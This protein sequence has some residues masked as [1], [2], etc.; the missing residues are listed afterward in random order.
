[1]RTVG[2]RVSGAPYTPPTQQS[3]SPKRGAL[4]ERAGWR[5]G[6]VGRRRWSAGRV[7][8]RV[9]WRGFG[10]AGCVCRVRW[11]TSD[12]DHPRAREI[13]VHVI[14]AYGQRDFHFLLPRDDFRLRSDG[15]C[16]IV[17]SPGSEKPLGDA[18]IPLRRNK[19]LVTNAS[20]KTIANVTVFRD[21]AAA[22]RYADGMKAGMVV[23]GDA[24]SYWVCTMAHAS[25][26]ERAGYELAPRAS[27]DSRRIR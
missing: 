25:R 3:A 13:R 24:P 7:G 9:R 19:M 27:A 1:M 17:F 18:A 6:R 26:L 12:R 16:G 8:G 4:P 21:H 2:F 15:T 11:A 23:M 20:G 5:V 10:C 22:Q 14:T